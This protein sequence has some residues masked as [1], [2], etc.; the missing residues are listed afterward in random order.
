M[1]RKT[2]PAVLGASLLVLS[3]LPALAQSSDQELKNEIEALKKGQQQIRSDIA[4]IKKLLQSGQRA[5][6]SGPDVKDKIFELGDNPVKGARTAKL[7]LVEFTD[8]Q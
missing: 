8:Y 2:V 5:A 7:T 1:N 6:P 3:A 4:E